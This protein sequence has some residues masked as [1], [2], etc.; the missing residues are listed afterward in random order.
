M[1]NCKN[2]KKIITSVA[3]RTQIIPLE[4]NCKCTKNIT[5]M[6]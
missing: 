6:L 3:L 2:M 1:D 4:A 5:I